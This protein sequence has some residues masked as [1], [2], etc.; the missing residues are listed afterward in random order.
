MTTLDTATVRTLV[1]P[2]GDAL[3]GAIFL[4]RY[5]RIV[6]GLV[7]LERTLAAEAPELVARTR[8]TSA[9]AFFRTTSAAVQRAVLGYPSAAF[10]LDVAE[11]LVR[12][13]SHIRF[14]EMHMRTHLLNFHRHAIAA[15]RLAKENYE[16]ETP[17]GENGLL[18]LPG[19]GEVLAGAAQPW[20]MLRVTIRGGE[21]AAECASGSLRI[22]R[23]PRMSNRVEWN[24]AD[25]DLRLPGRTAFAFEGWSQ[26]NAIRWSAPLEHSFAIIENVWPALGQE[27]AEGLRAILPVVG[28]RPDVHTSASFREAPGLVALSWTPDTSVLAEAIVHEYHHQKLNALLILDPLI[29]SDSAPRHYS[30]WR[31][32]PRPLTGVLHGAFA[33]QAVLGFWSAALTSGIP[34]LSEDRLRQR[35]VLVRRQVEW[36]IQTLEESAVFTSLG[37]ALVEAIDETVRDDAPTRIDDAAACH[38]EQRVLEHHDRWMRVHGS[39]E[40]VPVPDAAAVGTMAEILRWLGI[41]DVPLSFPAQGPDPLMEPVVHAAEHRNLAP[42]RAMLRAAATRTVWHELAEGHVAFVERRYDDAVH[43]YGAAVLS[44]PATRCLWQCL[45]FA[46]RHLGRREGEWILRNPAQANTVGARERDV[47]SLLGAIQ[48]EAELRFA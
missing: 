2:A 8:W 43:A 27:L 13:E 14:P 45:G 11:D 22:E 44:S 46:L 16:C 25:S 24:A 19:T 18:P 48:R 34:L 31:D 38:I 42:L 33:F 39:R 1:R 7:R 37:A 23:V 28:S 20:E 10:W 12:R 47:P 26:E 35:V 15:A 17:A 21:V 9:M 32:D 4:K 30:P 6:A 3:V 5:E 40:L 36:A 41:G 29:A